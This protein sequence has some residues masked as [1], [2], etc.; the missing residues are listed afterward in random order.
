MDSVAQLK[1]WIGKNLWNREQVAGW[2]RAHFYDRATFIST[3]SGTQHANLPVKTNSSGYVDDTFIESATI[4]NAM[5]A[6]MAQATV[7]GRA[8]GAGTGVPTDLT[9]TQLLAIIGISGAGYTPVISSS[10]GGTNIALDTTGSY[11]LKINTF[12][13]FNISAA[14]SSITAAG[15]GTIRLSLPSTVVT[16][17]ACFAQSSNVDWP[18][19]TQLFFRPT[20]GESYG[21]LAYAGDN[22]AEGAVTVAGLT[23]GDQIQIQ[24]WYSE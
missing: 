18:A 1:A 2:V 3:S 13:M 14:I 12:V 24:G 23:V 4:T 11:Y 5:L 20:N 10:G 17:T 15:T 9:A 8:S 6:N 16:G 7:K 22:I 19:G 21:I